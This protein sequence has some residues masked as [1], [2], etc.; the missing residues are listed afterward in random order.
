M[1]D[2]PT[3]YCIRCDKKLKQSVCFVDR[4]GIC[5]IDFPM[6]SDHYGLIASAYICDECITAL[7]DSNRI[8]SII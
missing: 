5:R 8:E 3:K 6:V 4:A 7:M 1:S 2:K